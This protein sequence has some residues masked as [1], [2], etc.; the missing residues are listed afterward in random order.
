MQVQHYRHFQAGDV[1]FGR[2]GSE[3]AGHGGR[4]RR[5]STEGGA[6]R[7]SATLFRPFSD[8]VVVKVHTAAGGLGRIIEEGEAITH[9]VRKGVAKARGTTDGCPGAAIEAVGEARDF[10]RGLKFAFDLEVNGFARKGNGG[11]FLGMIGVGAHHYERSGSVTHLYANKTIAFLKSGQAGA[12]AVF[13][14]AHVDAGGGGTA[15]AKGT[16]GE[17]IRSLGQ[18]GNDPASDEAQV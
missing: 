1:G 11:D 13:H 15:R 6:G 4:G 14:T 17:G 18:S 10:R 9:E 16:L 2:R 7:L 8:P 12:V 3:K 5:G